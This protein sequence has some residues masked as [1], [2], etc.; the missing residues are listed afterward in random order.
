MLDPRD[1]G[2]SLEIAS[3]PCIVVADRSHPAISHKP[4]SAGSKN[5]GD[6][7]IAANT[8]EYRYQQTRMAIRVFRVVGGC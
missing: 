7:N 6:G 4:V 2:V 5:H 8:H 1:L 3:R